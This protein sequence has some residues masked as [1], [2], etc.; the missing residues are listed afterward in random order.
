M[1][2]PAIIALVKESVDL[3]ALVEQYVPLRKQGT[4]WVGI[5]PF[6][7]PERTASFGVNADNFWKCFGCNESGDCFAFLMKIES[8]PF[9]EA[10]KRLGDIAGIAL[11]ERPV[12]RV[13]MA[14]AREEAAL[15]R[16]WWRKRHARMVA[17]AQREYMAMED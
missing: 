8:I 4:R 13:A 12:S 10:L 14:Y 2:P 15:C 7:G 9:H 6:H 5:C 3:V 11:D 1:I 17:M 16:W